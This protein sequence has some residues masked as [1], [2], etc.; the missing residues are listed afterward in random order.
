VFSGIFPNCVAA[1]E[2]C[3]LARGNVTAAEL[4]QAVWNLIGIVKYNSIA[5]GDFMLDYT[6]LKSVIVANLYSTFGWP[7]L[8]TLLDMPLTGNSEDALAALNNSVSTAEGSLQ[9][10]MSVMGIHC[11]DRTVRAASFDNFLPAIEQL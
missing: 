2:Q 9:A 7:Q 5:L 6:T 4:E 3:A 8:T 11:G 1:P 10:V